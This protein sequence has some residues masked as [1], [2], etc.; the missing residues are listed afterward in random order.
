[1]IKLFKNHNKRYLQLI[2]LHA[3]IGF[4]IYLFRFLGLFY[5]LGSIAF[6]VIWTFQTKNKN[7]LKTE[8]IML[9]K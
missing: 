6:F 1:M 9:I 3:A 8:K 7:E 4:A 2:G 5:F